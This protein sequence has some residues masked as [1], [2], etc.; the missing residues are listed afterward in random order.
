MEKFLVYRPK[1]G[2]V[3]TKNLATEKL[4]FAASKEA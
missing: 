2:Q 4:R 1:F 3:Y